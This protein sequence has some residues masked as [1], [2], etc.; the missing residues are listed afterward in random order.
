MKN[1]DS[2]NINLERYFGQSTVFALDSELVDPKVKKYLENVR[3]EALTTRGINRNNKQ[4]PTCIGF[5]SY[6]VSS[7]TLSDTEFQLP[8]DIDMVMNWFNKLK[9]SVLE[10]GKNI[11]SVCDSTTL[12]IFKSYVKAC[13]EKM[14]EDD[15]D[16]AMV[17]ILNSLQYVPEIESEASK[18]DEKWANNCIKLLKYG[19]CYDID[20][21][22]DIIT[23]SDPIPQNF[24]KW[25]GYI[26]YNEPKHC[27]FKRLSLDQL[28]KLVGYMITW[29]N[30]ILKMKPNSQSIAQWLF[31]TM[32]YLPNHLPASRIALLRELGK[33][34]HDILVKTLS[35]S[36]LRSCIQAPMLSSEMMNCTILPSKSLT[37]IDLVLLVISLKYGQRDLLII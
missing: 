2:L 34:A 17:N 25:Y 35:D 18:I 28:M 4:N 7:S 13:L 29:L 27:F 36:E 1:H 30:D 5:D 10:S 20:T 24:R 21:I 9:I 12:K 16:D 33:H 32:I 23:K 22:N 8:F 37:I 14:A 26:R 3:L 31:Y 15:K 19:K 6:H 11:S